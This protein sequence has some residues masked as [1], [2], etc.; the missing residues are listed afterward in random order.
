MRVRVLEVDN[1]RK[2]IS[3]SMKTAPEPEAKGKPREEKSSVPAGAKP[4]A[5][6]TLA[7]TSAFGSALADALKRR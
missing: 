1:R 6:A 4:L 3:L 5:K 7:S 2:R